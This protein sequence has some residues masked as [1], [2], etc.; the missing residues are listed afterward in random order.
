MNMASRGFKP[1]E[2][3]RRTMLARAANPNR[4]DTEIQDDSQGN[5]LAAGIEHPPVY[6]QLIGESLE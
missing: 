6:I 1:G 2:L 3:F 5:S 4:D